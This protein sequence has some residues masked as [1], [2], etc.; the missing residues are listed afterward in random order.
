M[1]AAKKREF[2]IDEKEY[3]GIFEDVQKEPKTA[4]NKR[5][6]EYT[7]SQLLSGI[8]EVFGD[9]KYNHANFDITQKLRANVS[10]FAALK[11]YHQTQ[12]LK[13]AVN[14]D[15]PKK[16][17]ET[18]NKLYNSSYMDTEMVH[19]VR[20]ARMA[21]NWQKYQG[22]KNTFPYLE[23]RPSSAGEQRN[24][25]R[26]LYG[27]I[28]PI[29]DAFWDSWLPPNDW[30]C[31]CSVRQ[32]SKT[33]DVKVPEDM[34]KP[35]K[36]MR[37]NAGKTGKVFS[38]HPMAARLSKKDMEVVNEVGGKLNRVISRENIRRDKS[39]F[40]N[41]TIKI[42]DK[43]IKLSGG[44]INKIL[45]QKTEDVITRNFLIPQLKDILKN[46]V[47]RTPIKPDN[48]ARLRNIEQVHIYDYQ[49]YEITVWEMKGKK[50]EFILHAFKITKG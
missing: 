27:V 35:P 12:H 49:N 40:V 32:V 47:P 31:R 19:T 18:L 33:S 38:D 46:G 30:G 20:S 28:K 43:Q 25:H 34:A 9:V 17:A 16:A 3:Q 8:D 2:G 24:E 5:L 15:E 48:S 26:K 23:Y 13:N 37:H 29:E 22:N 1:L 10:Q 7:N 6:F 21:K 45:S 11:S 44:G 36:V 39:V 42:G 4:I 41:Q 14:Q 50:P